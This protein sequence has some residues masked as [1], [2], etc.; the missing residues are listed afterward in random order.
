MP[1]RIAVVALVVLIGCAPRRA[2]L[3][4]MRG[5]EC[6]ASQDLKCAVVQFGIAVKEQP[7][8]NKYRF[9]LGL[10]LAHSGAF[11]QAETELQE[12]VRR[13]PNHPDAR[14]LLRIIQANLRIRSADAR[15]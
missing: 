5:K 1:S 7:D 2:E 15:Y 6:A 8:V 13:D 4:N 10:A 9:N 3:A 14:W 11:E 12:V